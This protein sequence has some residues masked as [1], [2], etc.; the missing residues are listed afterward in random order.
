MKKIIDMIT[1]NLAIIGIMVTVLIMAMA[2][3][4][5]GI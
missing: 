2:L 1:D 4:T 5:S 3:V